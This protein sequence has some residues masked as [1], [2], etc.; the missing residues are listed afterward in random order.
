MSAQVLIIGTWSKYVIRMHVILNTL[1]TS[2]VWLVFSH[3]FA[4]IYMYSVHVQITWLVQVARSYGDSCGLMTATPKYF[5][6]ISRD[7][8]YY[9]IFITFY[10][11]SSKKNFWL[12]Q[13][14]R[15]LPF[16]PSGNGHLFCI[17]NA[18]EN[19]NGPKG[20]QRVISN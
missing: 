4:S 19:M 15:V 14:T 7:F 20:F 12:K 13:D 16:I 1:H 18:Q 17:I 5:I 11:I 3:S 8:K 2:H 6:T 10:D 9:F